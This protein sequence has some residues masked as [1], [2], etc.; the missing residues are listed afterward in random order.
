[1]VVI[2]TT[3]CLTYKS[4]H[5]YNMYISLTES[6]KIIRIRLLKDA[7]SKI[8]REIKQ[9]PIVLKS[10]IELVPNFRVFIHKFKVID[11]YLPELILNKKYSIPIYSYLQIQSSTLNQLLRNFWILVTNFKTKH[12]Q[13]LFVSSLLFDK[14]VTIEKYV[15]N[16]FFLKHYWTKK[17]YL[18]YKISS[19][20]IW[21]QLILKVI[22]KEKQNTITDINTEN[23]QAKLPDTD[24]K[25]DTTTDTN[26][27]EERSDGNTKI[28]PVK[29]KS[30]F[31]WLYEN[32]NFQFMFFKSIYNSL[33]L[34][35]ILSKMEKMT[36][37]SSLQYKSYELLIK[38]YESEIQEKLVCSVFLNSK[39]NWMSLLYMKHNLKKNWKFNSER[40]LLNNDLNTAMYN[41]I[42]FYSYESL[43]KKRIY[44]PHI[45]SEYVTYNNI[46]Y[47]IRNYSSNM[48]LHFGKKNHT[49]E[50][51]LK[52]YLVNIYE[53][54][55]DH[56]SINI[57][58]NNYFYNL[59]SVQLL[60][61]EYLCFQEIVFN[62]WVNIQTI[63]LEQTTSKDLV[64]SLI[65]ERNSMQT[66]IESIKYK[67]MEYYK[68]RST[69]RI[70]H[71]IKLG[72]HKKLYWFNKMFKKWIIDKYPEYPLC[73]LRLQLYYNGWIRILKHLIIL[74]N[75]TIF[76]PTYN[77]QELF[78]ASLK[79]NNNK[80]KVN[81]R[82]AIDEY[83]PIVITKDENSIDQLDL[84]LNQYSLYCDDY[85][86]LL[87]YTYQD[88]HIKTF[89]NF[90]IKKGKKNKAYFIF[91]EVIKKIKSIMTI[92][93]LVF[94]KKLFSSNHRF[95]LHRLISMKNKTK[96]KIILYNWKKRTNIFYHEF[97]KNVTQVYVED[98]LSIADK[99]VYTLL[100]YSE[101]YYYDSLSQSN[102]EVGNLFVESKNNF[103]IKSKN[104][105]N[106]T[107]YKL[108]TSI[109]KPE[110]LLNYKKIY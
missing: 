2:V 61:L 23:K 98:L 46:M 103:T 13:W 51:L 63:F 83:E 32:I 15:S 81:Y 3:W 108:N 71:E 92:P 76:Y 17:N 54:K 41:Y 107:M 33:D 24:K 110:E 40:I 80:D 84:V 93:P 109:R 89:I 69:K 50:S 64:Y 55:N 65:L 9:D 7:V 79:L 12:H 43:H 21:H 97:F 19:N 58:K 62:K 90:L 10:L 4:S 77:N 73:R 74:K 29:L 75:I 56:N 47:E 95:L 86:W 59:F 60:E 48:N 106:I 45:I 100:T 39:F 6:I 91:F 96:S 53:L 68:F 104:K 94:L 35:N 5:I 36:K 30:K 70:K 25:E 22:R 49:L 28:I 87:Y 44:N 27:T 82:Q 18:H 72:L 67:I 101:D 105:K 102:D 66:I 38:H 88:Y 8:Q 52:W 31:D 11:T 57:N 34:C 78:E 85:R 37:K 1:M 42:L 14:I 16:S 99:I 26:I 20:T